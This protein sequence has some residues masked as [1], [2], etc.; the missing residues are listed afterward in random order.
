M[1]LLN[2]IYDDHYNIV[3]HSYFGR[4]DDC[5][6]STS[7]FSV[8]DEYNIPEITECPAVGGTLKQI[9]EAR[10]K[11]VAN[12]HPLVRRLVKDASLCFYAASHVDMYGRVTGS[13]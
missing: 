3:F 11:D 13:S 7:V 2:V 12:L 9:A 10:K 8:D 4:P 6:F 5:L 1:A